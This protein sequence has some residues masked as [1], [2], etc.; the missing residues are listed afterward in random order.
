MKSLH[1]WQAVQPMLLS[2]CHFTVYLYTMGSCGPF[3]MVSLACCYDW[4][5]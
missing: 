1:V 4:P 5:Y 3:D 2:L